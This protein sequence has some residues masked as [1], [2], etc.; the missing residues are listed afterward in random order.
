M[1]QCVQLHVTVL[2]LSLILGRRA[3]SHVAPLVWSLAS[4]EQEPHQCEGA[5][6]GPLKVLD[7]APVADPVY[8]LCHLLVMDHRL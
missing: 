1:C 3:P 7:P 8:V 6:S 2:G 4:Q 5:L